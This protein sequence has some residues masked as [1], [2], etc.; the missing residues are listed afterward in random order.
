MKNTVVTNFIFIRLLVKCN[1][2]VCKQI[3]EKFKTLVCNVLVWNF[4]IGATPGKE[5]DDLIIM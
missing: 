2:I 3:E 4:A 5:K 1:R